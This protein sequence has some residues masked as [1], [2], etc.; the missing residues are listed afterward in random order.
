[1]RVKVCMQKVGLVREKMFLH[2]LLFY[3]NY[4]TQIF[5]IR[6]CMRVKVCMQKVGVLIM[7]GK[8]LSRTRTRVFFFFFFL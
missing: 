6:S 7:L 1:M 8:H 4:L 2:K 3:V 5:D